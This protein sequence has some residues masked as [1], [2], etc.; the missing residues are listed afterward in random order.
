MAEVPIER[1]ARAYNGIGPAW[2][3]AEIVQRLTDAYGEFEPAA[4]I[5][6]WEYD[7]AAGDGELMRAANESFYRNCRRLA[8][9]MYPWWSPR[10]WKLLSTA[11][12]WRTLLNGFAQLAFAVAIVFFA[13]CRA[14]SVQQDGESFPQQ[15]RWWK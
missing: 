10:R 4:L 7:C 8:R 13:G 14:V 1:L 5:H 2:M 3:C 6:D 12:F 11:R 15:E 9:R